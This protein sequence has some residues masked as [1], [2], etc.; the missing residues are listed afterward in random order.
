MA[1]AVRTVPSMG[2]AAQFVGREA[3]LRSLHTVLDEGGPVLVYVHGIAG[4]GKSALVSAFA[5]RA[6]AAG[7][8]VVLLDCRSIEP[9]DRGFMHSIASAVGSRASTLGAVS[10]RLGRLGDRV[11]LVLDTYEV[12]R[13][14]D[15]W[16]RE[17]FLP[18]LGANVRLVL[19]GREPPVTEWLAS[20]RWH[21]L[22]RSVAL[23]PLGD[24]AALDLLSR[25]GVGE[26]EA[27]RI[28]R[29]VHGHPLALR[30]A[31]A[32]LSE[33]PDRSLEGEAIPMVV[34]SLARMYLADV[35]DPVTRA[36]PNAAASVRRV[37]RSLLRAMLP[38]AEPDDAFEHLQSLPFV[39]S[40]SD[41]LIVHDAVRDA[42]AGT[43][44][45]AR[46]TNW[47]IA[48]ETTI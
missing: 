15:T 9:T 24:A 35:G 17:T 20:A 30:L 36:A 39:Y 21:A 34:A 18:S 48:A 45:T 19:A 38:D 8:T 27:L 46:Q 42:I 26:R 7:A 10:E 23:E 12:F 44:T 4:V 1:N 2:S 47:L 29:F 32:T 40:G 37:T 14:L 33:R 11:V 5:D 16:L 6:R 31:V 25:N 43:L 22:V 28:N 3:E 13:F 41:G